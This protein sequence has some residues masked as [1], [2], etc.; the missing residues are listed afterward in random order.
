MVCVRRFERDEIEPRAVSGYGEHERQRILNALRKPES[1]PLMKE[2]F[3]TERSLSL[4]DMA[5]VQR[6]PFFASDTRSVLAVPVFYAGSL[7]GLIVLESNQEQA[8]DRGLVQ[9]IE[10][11]ADQAAIAVGNAKRYQEQL[12]RGEFLRRRADQLAS[13]LEVGRVLRSDRPLE[14]VLE[15]VA[16]G[17]QESVGFDRVL[18]S[19]VEGDPPIQRCVA[20]AGIPLV[21][22][23][24]IKE[25]P[26][27][28]SL[29]ERVMDEEFRVDQSYYVPG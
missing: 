15:E 21:T 4:S 1:H 13:V 14:D 8:F 27:P 9:F 2:A 5:P 23:E 26:Q 3:R 10:G 11:L 17:I 20:A 6:T 16:Y 19:V 22:F 25:A 24:R 12:E 28:W 18:V 29:V 7:N